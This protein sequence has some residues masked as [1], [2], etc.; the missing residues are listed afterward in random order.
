MSS[1]QREEFTTWV[2]R[3]QQDITARG[4]IMGYSL[5]HTMEGEAIEKLCS[6][7]NLAQKSLESIVAELWN[8]AE[9]DTDTRTSGTPQRYV[10]HAYRGDEEE[11]EPDGQFTFSLTSKSP[12]Q[13]G[14]RGTSSEPFTEKGLLGQ[15]MRQSEET[16]RMLIGYSESVAGRLAR[17]LDK[18]KAQNNDH[19]KERLGLMLQM[20]EL[21]DKNF[22]RELKRKEAQASQDRMEQIMQMVMGLAPMLL[23]SFIAKGQGSAVAGL[24]AAHSTP[25]NPARDVAIGNFLQSLDNEQLQTILATVGP[26]KGAVM[27]QI[28]ES[29]RTQK[30]AEAQAK[31]A[32]H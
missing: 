13:R 14:A 10:V 27:L 5:L 16:H 28:Y 3:C 19:Q 2:A 4:C 15:L 1:N 8:T 12:L 7:G 30:A 18:E 24:L 21:M 22:E 6:V 11:E 20:Q 32:T 29:Y 26:E 17:E 31:E 9:N 23:S 25:T